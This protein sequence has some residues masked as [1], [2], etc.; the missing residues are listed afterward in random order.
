[1]SDDH[2]TA[3]VK[4]AREA[5]VER[6]GLD[7]DDDPAGALGAA[8]T[9]APEAVAVELERL[10]G[11]LAGHSEAG[12]VPGRP[13]ASRQLYALVDATGEDLYGVDEGAFWRAVD[14]VRA[15]QDEAGAVGVYCRGVARRL[16]YPSENRH[17]EVFTVRE[18]RVALD[19]EATRQ[20]TAFLA[21]RKGLPAGLET[22][23]ARALEADDDAT[24][25]WAAKTFDYAS[26]LDRSAVVEDLLTATDD[27]LATV[28]AAAVG[29]LCQRLWLDEDAPDWSERAMAALAAALADEARVVRLRAAGVLANY[30]SHLAESA[31]WEGLS[32]ETR[33]RVV[34]NFL[35]VDPE[36]TATDQPSWERGEDLV[37]SMGP[38]A[39][40]A[41]EA[42]LREVAWGC[43]EPDRVLVNPNRSA[44][45]ALSYAARE[46]PEGL[47]EPGWY[48]AAIAERGE[49]R[50]IDRFE[51][52][53]LRVVAERDV[54]AVEEAIPALEAA[55]ST[56][57]PADASRES[58]RTLAVVRNQRP[59]LVDVDTETLTAAVG[60]V[61]SHGSLDSDSVAAL[62][63][64]DPDVGGDELRAACGDVVEEGDT[65]GYA[66]RKTATDAPDVVLETLPAVVEALDALDGRGLA[67]A[68]DGLA[69]AAAAAPSQV[70]PHAAVLAGH[71]ASPE[72]DAR[73]AAARALV[74]VGEADPDAPPE[75]ARPLLG[76]AGG[77][78]DEAW[79]AGTIASSD[80]EAGRDLVTSALD[81]ADPSGYFGKRRLE[82]V[83]VEVAAG[84][85]RFGRELAGWL[86]ASVTGAPLEGVDYLEPVDPDRVEG[87]RWVAQL[88]SRLADAHPW[89]VSPSVEELVR[90]LEEGMVPDSAV[91]DVHET[92]GAAT[93]EA[94]E[95]VGDAL[96]GGLERGWE[97]RPYGRLLN[98]VAAADED[99]GR[100]LLA[101]VL[102][103]VGR[104][105]TACD[106]VRAFAQKDP[107]VA[108]AYAEDVVAAG[109]RRR[110]A[111]ERDVLRT[112]N[113][114]A[115]T[116]DQEAVR[117]ALAAHYPDRESFVDHYDSDRAETV[118]RRA[119]FEDGEASSV[120]DRRDGSPGGDH[121]GDDDGS[122]L[123]SLLSELLGDG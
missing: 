122:L 97:S 52:E 29:A 25:V 18:L 85:E 22:D 39:T 27:D 112:L 75:R 116:G 47:S 99:A 121:P 48:A 67:A 7:V 42:E 65:V 79:P 28:R 1:M 86:V 91:G 80:R 23:C 123:E 54:A 83:L 14:A 57:E 115:G 51:A 58:A 8:P 34:V 101:A 72:A 12:D 110:P 43:E 94:P 40:W 59:D 69:A 16:P 81:R 74:S 71:L 5:L 37:G 13:Q 49:S 63:V 46:E 9:R 73:T 118:A 3:A 111:H 41:V 56:D 17:S 93:R 100:E 4:E 90:A 50:D 77:P 98:G 105:E 104:S 114:M 10:A 20:A 70:A 103:R 53:L 68:L 6:L 45:R 106:T 87:G 108:A 26:S 21:A 109:A 102:E 36:E 107:E 117:R 60:G 95:I 84:D 96:S 82:S 38:A 120:P 24:R 15:C 119:L 113:T 31:V 92:V 32:P 66:V 35:G 11:V 89:T 2:Q 62:A 61:T 76:A 33:G 44:R 78:D 19:T 88:L 30:P 64:V 55:V